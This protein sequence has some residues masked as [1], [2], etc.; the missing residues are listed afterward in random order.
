MPEKINISE[1]QI[2]IKS[3]K[4][5]TKKEL[6]FIESLISWDKNNILKQS[7]DELKILKELILD[8]LNARL[9]RWNSNYIKNLKK[10]TEEILD[11]KLKEL[12]NQ[13]Q[14]E[15][16][17]K[18]E[19]KEKENLTWE[20]KEEKFLFW[21]EVQWYDFLLDDLQYFRLR[22]Y[23]VQAITLLNKKLP[24]LIKEYRSIVSQLEWKEKEN[25]INAVSK[26]INNADKDQFMFT[27]NFDTNE[28]IEKNIFK[29]LTNKE[30]QLV[31]DIKESMKS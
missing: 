30:Q 31:L 23:I 4:K 16:Q 21:E 10:K 27:N 12:E 5:L 18:A 22:G 11:K 19:N 28:N 6:K 2:E 14:V 20:K 15:T 13:E 1:K 7:R 3:D 29:R 9:E 8:E 25:I 17:K 24:L 26:V